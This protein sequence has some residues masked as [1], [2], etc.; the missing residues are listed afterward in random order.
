[1]DCLFC[2]IAAGDIPAMIVDSDDTSVAFLDIEPFQDGH[3]L[4]IPRKHVT[5][6]LDDDGELARISPMVTKVARHL[7]DSLGAS[8]VN[9]VSNAGEVA[10]QSVHH[11]HVHVI[12]RYDREPGINAIR[13]TLPRR[14]LEEVA[15]LVAGE[16]DK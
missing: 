2:S 14:R 1:M 9:I 5:S 15:A 4:V 8:G 11:L 12:P 10:G 6:A 13:S 3:T 7:V 16:S